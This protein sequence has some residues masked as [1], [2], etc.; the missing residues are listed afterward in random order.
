MV[1][2]Q[3]TLLLRVVMV[4]TPVMR[5]VLLLPVGYMTWFLV[6]SQA[7][8]ARLEEQAWLRHLHDLEFPKNLGTT[9]SMIIILL[10]TISFDL[11]V[12][13]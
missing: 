10:I 11:I 8:G 4:C 3:L 1:Y 2:L 5:N 9:H 12:M 6:Q 13:K 7:A